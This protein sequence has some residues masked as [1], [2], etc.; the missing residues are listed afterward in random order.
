[1]KEARAYLATVIREGGRTAYSQGI[2]PTFIRFEGMTSFRI[3]RIIWSLRGPRTVILSEPIERFQRL[4]RRFHTLLI[5]RRA[6]RALRA[7]E[8]YGC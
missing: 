3:E 7:R 4:W 5:G 1:M 2:S 8:L 6:I